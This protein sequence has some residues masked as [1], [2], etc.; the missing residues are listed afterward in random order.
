MQS[1]SLTIDKFLEHA[2]KWAGAREIVS[3]SHQG[4]R[5]HTHYEGLFQRSNQL[6]GALQNINLQKGDRVAT[7]AWNT[8]DHLEIYFATMGCGMIC[9][10]LNPRFSEAHLASIINEAQDKALAISQSLLPMLSELLAQCPTI[11]TVIVLDHNEDT[12]VPE[13]CSKVSIWR[14]NQLL[15]THGKA[16]PW[17][18]FEE[19]TPAGLCFTSGTTGKP[20]GVIYTHRSNYL[21]TLRLLQADAIAL[22]AHDT[23]LVAVPMFHAN[24]WGLPFAAPAVGAKLVLPGRNADGKSLADLIEAEG[25][26][27]AAGVQTVWLSLIDYLD[28]SGRDLPTL[29]RVLIGGSKCPDSLIQRLESR[30]GAQIQTSWGM[31]ELSPLGTISSPLEKPTAVRS[32]G[33]PLAGLDLKLTDQQGKTLPAQRGHVGHLKVKGHSV[34][35]QY[36]NSTTPDVDDEGYFDTGDLAIINENGEMSICGRAKDL[37]KSGGEWINPSEIEEIVGNYDAVNQVAVIG[38]AHPKWGERPVMIVEAYDSANISLESLQSHLKGK[39]PDWWMP[40]EL[41]LVSN[42]PLAATGKID[43]IALREQFS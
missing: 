40:S 26:T 43:K 11:E 42:M 7:L 29:K 18:E 25:V 30:L 2:S 36:F 31:T 23:V 10:T 33:K 13:L 3:V 38:V 9:H 15:T 35:N 21:H 27:I 14:H 37:I 41:K 4:K 12:I 8:L 28:E 39:I 24:G 6:S 17:G 22:S 16:V 19:E 32:A 5:I 20:K 1:F 34:V